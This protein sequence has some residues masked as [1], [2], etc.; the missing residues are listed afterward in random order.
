VVQ[1]NAETDDLQ[2][3]HEAKSRLAWLGIGHSTLQLEPAD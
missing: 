2:L 1:R 3:L